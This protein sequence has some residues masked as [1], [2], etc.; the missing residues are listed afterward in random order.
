MTNGH[1][2]FA[3]GWHTYLYVCVCVCVCVCVVCVCGD[4]V[5]G[6]CVCV[7]VVF[8][9]VCVCMCVRVVCVLRCI[10]K[11]TRYCTLIPSNDTETITV[12]YVWRFGRRGSDI[13]A[14]VG[15][16]GLEKLEA[17]TA[18]FVGPIGSG[19]I[20]ART[21]SSQQNNICLGIHRQTR[22]ATFNMSVQTYSYCS[23]TITEPVGLF[24]LS[25]H[26]STTLWTRLSCINYM[27]NIYS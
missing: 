5:C 9:C 21:D 26:F 11:H 23:Y 25:F 14:K 27:I 19:Y 8:V 15:R 18:G 3:V 7:C 20:G 2:V 24:A 1:F 12:L 10:S 17:T 4:C 6:V 16:V 13:I 22:V